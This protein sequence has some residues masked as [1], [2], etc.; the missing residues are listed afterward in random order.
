[1]DIYLKE[2][3]RYPLLDA[4]EERELAALYKRGRAAQHRLQ[5]TQPLSWRE[6]SQL[7]AAVS[8]GRAARSRLIEGNLRLVIK[9]IGPYAHC[10]LAF[11]DLVQEGNVGLIHAVERFDHQRGVR[12]ATY[13]G[14]WIKQSV[15]R[16]AADHGRTIRRPPWLVQE[17]GTL[18]KQRTA[19]EA[20]LQRTPSDA[21][22]AQ[23]LCWTV[24]RVREIAGYDQPELSLE[25]S[26]SPQEDCPLS[27]LLAD[28]E[29]PDPVEEVLRG[30]ARAS[31]RAA[32]RTHLRPR[33]QRLLRLRYG[34]DGSPRQT[35][36][37]VAEQL[38]ITAERVRQIEKSAL[39][40]LRR[41][42]GRDEL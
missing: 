3:G 2:V 28:E 21:E 4:Q 13:A 29:A 31:L 5:Q 9:L 11:G 24:H 26:I 15:L 7:Q 37:Q 14:W 25:M 16:A 39:R 34:L 1:V 19:L 33:D 20:R 27:E 40:R 35:L 18:R 30:Q 41:A 23:A 8:R 12:F 10:G 22:L 38:G 36:G 32:I 17:I 42:I 6:R